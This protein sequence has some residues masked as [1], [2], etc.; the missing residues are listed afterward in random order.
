MR[1]MQVT[2][3]GIDTLIHGYIQSIDENNPM[4]YSYKKEQFFEN[5][6]IM[7]RIEDIRGM[8]FIMIKKFC[9]NITVLNIEDAMTSYSPL[10][11][12]ALSL[13]LSGE[14]DETFNAAA[15]K[16]KDVELSFS[17]TEDFIH[18]IA[19]DRG[20]TIE[21][22]P[23]IKARDI[24][25]MRIN[26][27]ARFEGPAI[28]M[29]L[30]PFPETKLRR[31]NREWIEANTTDFANTCI[32]EFRK[33][34]YDMMETKLG[35]VDV[36]T[37]VQFNQNYFLYLSK[38]TMD[39]ECIAIRSPYGYINVTEARTSAQL[40]K[41]SESLLNQNKTIITDEITDNDVSVHFAVV[42]DI[43]TMM[44]FMALS[45]LVYYHE[46]FKAIAGVESVLNIPENLNSDNAQLFANAAK[47]LDTLRLDFSKQ[48]TDE[49]KE[50]KKVYKTAEPSKPVHFKR[51]A[52]YE[53]IPRTARIRYTI[54]GTLA[55]IRS[56]VEKAGRLEIV[57]DGFNKI[58]SKVRNGEQ[59]THLLLVTKS[60]KK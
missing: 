42:S 33:N 37:D 31:K 16:I 17:S 52:L 51:I 1:V 4:Y 36:L 44:I 5:C 28:M 39:A 57:P 43:T 47:N 32:R 54:R 46:D 45:N 29:L 15:K 27:I 10:D 3:Y 14:P 58:L 50:Q 21:E 56:F 12:Y 38:N 48:L 24:G 41:E 26:I 22:H 49:E 13:P 19:N 20:E 8:E 18:R 55:D 40:V 2:S 59:L 34:F 7:M 9:P 60:K 30:S 11:N 53:Y 23:L 6:E 35:S 25:S